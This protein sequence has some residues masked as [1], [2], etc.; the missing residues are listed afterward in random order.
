NSSPCRP[1]LVPL[2]VHP[3]IQG[4]ARGHEVNTFHVSQLIRQHAQLAQADAA[5]LWREASSHGVADRTGLL[6]NLLLHKMTEAALFGELR[7]PANLLRRRH[8]GCSSEVGDFHAAP[9]HNRD[10]TVGE[11]YDATGVRQNGKN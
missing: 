10:L 5:A 11:V 4:S 2:A 9:A 6:V 8:A 3:Y 7:V 1:L